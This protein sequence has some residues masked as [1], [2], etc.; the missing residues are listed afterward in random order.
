MIAAFGRASATAGITTC[1]RL[2]QPATGSQPNQS[3]KTIIA[4]EP[5]TKLGSETP[6]N[7][8][9]MLR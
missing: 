9:I 8:S 5:S 2:P 6:T 1:R 3:E 4:A 7:A